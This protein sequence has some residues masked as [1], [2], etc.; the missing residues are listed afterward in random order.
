MILQQVPIHKIKPNLRNARTHPAK[1]IR[2]IAKSMEAFGFVNPLLLSEDYDLIAGHGR[3]EAAELLGLTEV[4]VIILPGLSS[5]KRR[6]LAIADNRITESGGWNYGRL[7]IEIPE[8]TDLL[9]IDGLDVAVLGFEPVEIEE[10]QTGSQRPASDPREIIDPKW[11]EGN[12]VSESGDL[13][14]LGNHKL[15]CGGSSTAGIA[16]LM[17]GCRADLA[18]IN[19]SVATASSFDFIASLSL[20][21][22]AAAAVSRQGAI[23]F[24]STDRK[25][26]SAC[27]TAAKPIYGDPLD[28]IVWLKS[29]AEDGSFYRNQYELIAMFRLGRPSCTTVKRGRSGSSRSNVWRHPQENSARP[30]GSEAPGTD[31]KPVDLII[32]AV[33]DCTKNG[34]IILDLFAGNGSTI[35]ASE[36]LG[37]H[38]RALEPDPRLVD[39]TIRR[40]QHFTQSS[41]LHAGYGLSFDHIASD[42]KSAGRVPATKKSARRPK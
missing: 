23:H 38:T 26:V 7:A 14:L 3:Y 1:Q 15:L 19:S 5:A 30:N 32:E 34:D 12:P 6:A 20:A 41:A 4:P 27:M 40:W 39:L 31:P 36:R 10:I 16:D 22:N 42:R 8:L 2:Q 11:C 33:K 24:V 17:T 37:R 18:F 28:L 35:L 13:W 9:Q 21:L 25:H 29:K